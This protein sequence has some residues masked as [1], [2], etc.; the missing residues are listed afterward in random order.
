MARASQNPDEIGAAAADY[1][2]LF[3]L[4]AVGWMWLRM[5]AIGT[6]KPATSGIAASK[7]AT[8][9]FYVTKLLPDARAL[10]A[11]ID[12]GAAPVMTLDATAF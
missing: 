7:L 10:A 4:V 2:R 9:E 8:A 12:A 5:A 3:G 6:E 1:L 11:R